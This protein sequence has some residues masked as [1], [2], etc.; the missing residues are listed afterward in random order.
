MSRTFRILLAAVAATAV[1]SGC[2]KI[3]HFFKGEKPISTVAVPAQEN[4]QIAMLL[5]DFTQLVEREGP[6]VVNI[7]AV[8]EAQPAASA[9]PNALPFPIPEDDPFYEFFKRFMPNSPQQQEPQDSETVSFGSGFI[10]SDDGYILTN[11]HV[12]N[13]GS[14]IKVMLTDKREFKAKLL[15]LDKRAD[16]AVLK[17]QASNL[18]TVKIGDPAALKVGE[19]VAAIGAPFGFENSVTAGIVSAKGRSLPDENYVPFIQTDVPI[20]P[21]N[22]GGPL[23]NLKG[24]VVGINSQI[25]SRSG[26]F[27][28]I[29][30][31]IPIDIAINVAEQIKAKGKVS[32]GQL[33]VNIQ[34]VSQE[35][36]QSFGLDR[37]RG[38]LVVR[39]EPSGPA[40]RAGLQVGDIVLS[41]NGKPVES[42]KDLPMVIGSLQP[43]T[44]VKLGIWRKG[45]E[46]SVDVVLGELLAE[47]TETPSPPKQQPQPESYQIGKLGLTLSELTPSQ[48]SDLGVKGGLL[49]QKAQ[50]PAARAGLQHGDV[51]IGLNQSE[52]TTIKSLEKAL[53]SSDNNIAL[54]VRRQDSTLFVPLRLD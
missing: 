8:R 27:M 7:Q 23:F 25:Y 5:P 14:Q 47:Q 36:A 11:S 19:W 22:S 54:L 39:V 48:R 30:F 31:A 21:G 15:G 45:T 50:G 28:G 52:I 17:I 34:E 24:Q 18:P 16:I 35:L 37:P 44:R 42:S 4:G 2:D 33:G 9:G 40:A 12:V 1:L 38:A 13:G 43:N 41:V 20:N 29:S 10:I 53:A 6:A 3:Q 46:K 49:I 32:R 26:G 51:I